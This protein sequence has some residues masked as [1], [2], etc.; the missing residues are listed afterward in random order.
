MSQ[1]TFQS[2]L[3]KEGHGTN[4]VLGG[5]CGDEARVS[6]VLAPYLVYGGQ[7]EA[8]ISVAFA[9]YVVSG[10]PCVFPSNPAHPS[11]SSRYRVAVPSL[12]NRENKIT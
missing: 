11:S 10:G 3:C 8:V 5:E 12:E 6:V 9:P 7:L 2:S 4:L 1:G